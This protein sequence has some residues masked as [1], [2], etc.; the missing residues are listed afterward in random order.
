M[1]GKRLDEL[2]AEERTKVFVP[3]TVLSYQ[4]M[5]NFP[6]DQVITEIEESKFGRTAVL[7]VGGE[8][9]YDN[10]LG[11]DAGFQ[12]GWEVVKVAS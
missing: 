12:H 6:R 9:G 11:I 4:D 3:G 10:Y 1:N 5:S 2:T 7:R 8:D